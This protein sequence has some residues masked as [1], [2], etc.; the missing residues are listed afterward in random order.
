M[1]LPGGACSDLKDGER[2]GDGGG[3]AR[4]GSLAIGRNELDGVEDP[5]GAA[6][7]ESDL[8]SRYIKRD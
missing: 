3:N 7:R 6:V 8:L 4:E 1:A 2:D 5:E